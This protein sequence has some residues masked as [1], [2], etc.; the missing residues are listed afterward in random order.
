M[1]HLIQENTRI[2]S[3]KLLF[4]I[5]EHIKVRHDTVES[6]SEIAATDPIVQAYVIPN[7][8]SV[9]A[10]ALAAEA[11]DTLSK[12]YIEVLLQVSMARLDSEW[13]AFDPQEKMQVVMIADSI[14]MLYPENE[15]LLKLAIAFYERMCRLKLG[16]GSAEIEL[17]SDLLDK[18]RSSIEPNEIQPREPCPSCQD[19][20]LF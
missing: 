2:N 18:K 7:E 20:I 14:M 6:I 9:K 3:A 10:N 12:F 13:L 17:A 16:V 1:G 15:K 8:V 4:Y 19:Y 5:N 11:K